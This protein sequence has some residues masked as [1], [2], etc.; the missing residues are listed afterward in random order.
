[1]TRAMEP[2]IGQA[3]AFISGLHTA[4]LISA[5]LLGAAAVVIALGGSA[6][7]R[8]EGLTARR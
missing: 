3:H 7:H 4:R 5:L 8:S 6:K 2:N 1:M